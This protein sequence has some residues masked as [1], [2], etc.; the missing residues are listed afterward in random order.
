VW[1]SSLSS[2]LSLIPPPQW[3]PESNQFDWADKAA[4][5][6]TPDRSEDSVR[7][8][9]WQSSFFVHEARKNDKRF[10]SEEEFEKWVLG[11]DKDSV[12]NDGWRYFF[13]R[14]SA[15]TRK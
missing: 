4:N 7:A 1:P 9:Q 11:E 12:M 8:M 5:D 15:Y 2:I 10:E 6:A 3:H 13:K 14:T